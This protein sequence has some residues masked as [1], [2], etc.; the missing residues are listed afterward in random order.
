VTQETPGP[1]CWGCPRLGKTK[2]LPRPS[3]VRR[4]Q[5]GTGARAPGWWV[6]WELPPGVSAY[7]GESLDRASLAVLLGVGAEALWTAGGILGG[8]GPP[9]LGGPTQACQSC[10]SP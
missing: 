2:A 6:S 4:K 9:Q 8:A 5:Q 3:R 10:P 1:E 7:G